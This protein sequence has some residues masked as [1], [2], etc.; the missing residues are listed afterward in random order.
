MA[1]I[2]Q[3]MRKEGLESLITKMLEKEG[4]SKLQLSFR[5]I[6]KV[7]NN[8]KNSITKTKGINY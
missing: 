3:Q 5:D 6:M 1:T 4:R 2:K 7:L 8:C